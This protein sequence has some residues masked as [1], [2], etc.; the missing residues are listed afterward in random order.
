MSKK[1]SKKTNTFL[2]SK[3]KNSKVSSPTLVNPNTFGCDEVKKEELPI[4]VNKVISKMRLPNPIKVPIRKRGMTSS[5]EEF[6]CHTNVETIIC[7][8][9]GRRMIGYNI[10]VKDG[11][12]NLMSHSLWITPEN[13]LVDVTKKHKEQNLW[14]INKGDLDFQ[15]FIPLIE[16]SNE[17]HDRELGFDSVTIPKKYKRYGYNYV[18]YGEQDWKK[19][20]KYLPTLNDLFRE[21]VVYFE[22]DL[23]DRE[24][25][26]QDGNIISIEEMKYCRKRI[27]ET[28]FSLP[29]LFTGKRISVDTSSIKT[30]L[31]YT[32]KSK[33]SEWNLSSQF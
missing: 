7:V 33:D 16:R 18:P 5:G 24:V 19:G 22:K 30:P 1:M 10:G 17:E 28:C 14:K 23:V 15:Y 26:D 6:R 29:S 4:F 27:M 32:G 13:E 25:E 11:R 2:Q 12:M 3:N 21:Q 9:G 20:K 31:I 8:Y